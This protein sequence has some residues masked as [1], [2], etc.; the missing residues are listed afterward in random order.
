VTTKAGVK[1]LDGRRALITGAA[2]GIGSAVVAAFRKHGAEV[3]GVDLAQRSHV[4]L[5]DVTDEQSVMEAFASGP[6]D[7]VV[8]AAGIATVGTVAETPV[9]V[10]RRVLEVNLVGSFLVASVAAR[11]A[12]TGATVT[13]IASQAARKGGARWGAYCASKF[14]LIGL[15]ESLS[16]ELA[17]IGARVNCVCPGT[18]ETDMS[19]EVI[20]A[21]ADERNEPAA[22]VR[23]HYADGVPL[24]RFATP[25]EVADVCVFLSSPLAR[26]VTGASIVV[27]GGE[28]S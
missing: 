6:F 16:Q 11:Q 1:L 26:Y 5:C 18:V 7:D 4:L 14:G 25:D 13:F 8:H 2:G 9:E 22:G 23:A 20:A 10:F 27:D 24:G 19:K 12:S 17:P 28:L 15:A 21:L 3:V